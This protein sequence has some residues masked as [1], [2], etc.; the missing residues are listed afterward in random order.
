MVRQNLSTGVRSITTPLS[1]PNWALL[2]RELLRIQAHAIELFYPHYFDK[3]GYQLCVPR[4]GGDDGPDDAAENMAGWTVLHS[5]GASDSVLDR[6]KTAWE[7][8][9]QQYTEAKTTEVPFAREG[10]YYKEFPVSLSWD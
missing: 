8:H 1:P 6:Y 3:R 9:I 10:M 4:W 2:Q 5:L 7:G